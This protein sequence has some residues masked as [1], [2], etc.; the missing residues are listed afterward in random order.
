[1][2]VAKLDTRKMTDEQRTTN[3]ELKILFFI[4]SINIYLLVDGYKAR[5]KKTRVKI[6]Y[7]TRY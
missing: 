4:F 7:Y 5:R 2:I 6:N 1:M 3:N